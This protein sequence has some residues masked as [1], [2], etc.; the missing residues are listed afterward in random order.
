MGE[1]ANPNPDSTQSRNSRT[2]A[3]GF[4]IRCLLVSGLG[5]LIAA[6]IC[7]P[8]YIRANEQANRRR[9]YRQFQCLGQAMLLYANENKGHFPSRLED[10]ILTQDI[11]GSVFVC[12]S[13]ND[14][15]AKGNSPEE[16][17][18]DFAKPSHHS[19]LRAPPVD[20]TKLESYMQPF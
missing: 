2:G 1:P 13:S 16:R 11:S 5:L 3:R 8:I 12:P 19:Y 6:V 15:P 18:A 20:R 10:L 9:C 4:R 7:I 17:A 14:T